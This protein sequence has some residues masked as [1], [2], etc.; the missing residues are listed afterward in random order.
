MSHDTAGLTCIMDWSL[1]GYRSRERQLAYEATNP[2][3][4]PFLLIGLLGS[5]CS[6]QILD[7]AQTGVLMYMLLGSNGRA[8]FP[9]R[10][11]PTNQQLYAHTDT[12]VDSQP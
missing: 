10:V 7:A 2:L 8:Q 5:V 1:V 3:A 9:T 11:S 12:V 4:L 6:S